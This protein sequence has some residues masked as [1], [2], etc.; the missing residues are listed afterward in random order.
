MKKR[1][2]AIVLAFLAALLMTAVCTQTASASSQGDYIAAEHTRSNGKPYYIMVNRTYCT[3]TIYGLDENGYYTVPVK[4]M[5]CSVGRQGHLTPSG[6]FTIGR[7]STWTLMVGGVYG[8][9]TSQI[10]GSILFHSV[11]Y[12]KK[13]PS[14]LITSMYNGLGAPASLGCVRLQTE[15]AKWIYDNCATGT[16]VTVYDG[17]TSP[18][19]LGKP[20]KLVDNIPSN[21][22]AKG[23]DPTDPRAENPW[24]AIL[25][26]QEPEE[27]EQPVEPE[28][29]RQP[30]V[31]EVPDVLGQPQA[32]SEAEQPE[33][34]NEAEQPEEP[35]EPEQPE[36]PV[37][38]E[39]PEEP[40]EPEQPE[41]PAEP[42][43]PEEPAEPEQPEEPAEPEQP[44]EP[45]EPEQPDEPEIQ[46]YDAPI[47]WALETRIT[48]GDENGMIPPDMV[49]TQIRVLTMLW[50]AAGEPKSTAQVPFDIDENEWYAAPLHWAAEKGMIDENFQLEEECV[51]SDAVTYL[52][53]AANGPEAGAAGG[54]ID[55]D[56]DADF[57]PAVA[58]A[59]ENGITSGTS[60][61]T[62]SP[63]ESCT[64]AHILTF[65]Y[66]AYY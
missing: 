55:V 43:Q 48:V 24:H 36:E 59:V 39:Q 21:H 30:E 14:T 37:E 12:N 8:Q 22:P 9:Y 23:W 27:P 45:D 46:Y 20:D 66:R 28:V 31:V 29:P 11:C 44:E 4:A 50:R 49:C 60:E 34:P 33:E 52:W 16:K 61:D 51:R 15:D 1:F 42:E 38:P 2:P 53:L 35:A 32:P 26:A 40:A 6:T 57:A 7:K 10:N 65:L 18:G 64:Q 3:V 41:E 54:F 56:A 47:A 5:I 63:D 58:W 25:A 17:K 62:F 19:A 13:D